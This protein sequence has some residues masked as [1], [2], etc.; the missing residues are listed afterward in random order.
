LSHLTVGSQSYIPTM[1]RAAPLPPVCIGPETNSHCDAPQRDGEFLHHF[2]ESAASADAELCAEQSAA[3]ARAQM[4][5]S[6]A[7]KGVGLMAAD[8]FLAGMRERAEAAQSRIRAAAA[9][10]SKPT[11]E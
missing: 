8:Q 3:L 4:A 11:T 10:K 9:A 7:D 2:I 5:L 6:S 1:S